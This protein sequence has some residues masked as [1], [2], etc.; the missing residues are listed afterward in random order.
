[1]TH[2]RDGTYP[3]KTDEAGTVDIVFRTKDTPQPEL[4]WLPEGFESSMAGPSLPPGSH[5]LSDLSDRVFGMK[6][7]LGERTLPL[8]NSSSNERSKI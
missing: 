3:V 6:I 5:L 2:Q 1:M 8:M 4:F 7:K